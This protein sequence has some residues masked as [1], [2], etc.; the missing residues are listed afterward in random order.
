MLYCCALLSP[1]SLQ[2]L[3]KLKNFADDSRFD[4]IRHNS[5]LDT[6]RS[7]IDEGYDDQKL[8]LLQYDIFR[9]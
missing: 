2:V 9:L 8:L 4:L 6:T 5:S 1:S 7:R 3:L